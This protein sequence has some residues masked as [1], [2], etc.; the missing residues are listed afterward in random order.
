MTNPSPIYELHIQPTYAVCVPQR[1]PSN[2]LRSEKQ[3]KNEQNLRKNK[4]KEQMSRKAVRRLTNSVN[5]LVASAKQKWIF[6]VNFITLTLPT[7]DHN[8]TDHQFKK[9]LL[10]N[11]INTCR[12]AYG[13]KNYVWKVEAQANGNIHAHFTTDTFIHWKDV[14][15]VWNRILDKK[16]II[17]SYRNKHAAMSFEQYCQVYSPNGERDI[18]QLQSSFSAGCSSNWSDPNSTDV[19]AVH[20]VKD[21]AAYLAKYM[22]KNEDDRR[23]I[24]G[25][26]WGCSYNLSETNKLI[27]EI[28]GS[29]D[30][31]VISELFK[32]EIAYKE[33]TAIS[34]LTKLPFRVGEIFFYKISDWGTV[35]RGKLLEIFDKHRF[36][37][38]YNIDVKSLLPDIQ[39]PKDDIPIFHLPL[40]QLQNNI[41]NQLNFSI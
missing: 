40:P 41:S 33:L 30:N 36:N 12:A 27:V 11:F 1:L 38:R 21:I 34:S 29:Q 15:K 26:L 14:R 3:L 13:L 25:R 7:L 6:K 35:I 23:S 9:D 18:K 22:S 10:H 2:Y 17:D 20:K 32:P 37:I 8:L 5:W 16:G 28:Q 39:V 24:K 19:H 4:P 31:E